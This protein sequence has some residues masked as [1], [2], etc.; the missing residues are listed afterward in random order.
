MLALSPLLSDL[1]TQVIAYFTSIYINLYCPSRRSV[2]YSIIPPVTFCCEKCGAI[3]N[4]AMIYYL[5]IVAR[6]LGLYRSLSPC[7]Q[8]RRCGSSVQVFRSSSLTPRFPPAPNYTKFKVIFLI[9]LLTTCVHVHAIHQEHLPFHSLCT[10][11]AILLWSFSIGYWG[12]SWQLQAINALLRPTPCGPSLVHGSQCQELFITTSSNTKKLAMLSA[13]QSTNSKAPIIM[14]YAPGSKAIC[15]DTGASSCISND[16]HDFI[17]YY[18]VTDQVI[19]GISSGL[20]VEGRSTLRWIIRDDNGNDVILHVSDALHV[21]KI[22]L[23]LLCPQ[24][25]AQQTGKSNDGFLAGGVNGVFTFDGFVRTVPYN[26]RNGLPLLFAADPESIKSTWTPSVPASC[27]SDHV[28]AF[29]TT[30]IPTSSDTNLSRTQWKLLHIHE[31]MGHIGF[32]EL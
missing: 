10:F 23:C 1:F 15:I 32:D 18:P 31:H 11:P 2:Y 21:P 12:Q 26:G 9:Y 24:Q 7:W 19:S 8:P 14:D 28:R 4:C 16:K 5:F 20:K 27:T 17:T 13:W 29:L 25:I 6:S 22:P 3:Y 30:E